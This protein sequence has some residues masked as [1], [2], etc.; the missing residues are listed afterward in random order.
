MRT[1]ILAAMLTA[2]TAV[3]GRAETIRLESVG[4]T[5]LDKADVPAQEAGPAAAVLVRE[6]QVVQ[7]GD[8]LVQLDD[9][10]RQ[11]ELQRARIERQ[12]AAE[13]AANDVKVRLGR[14]ALELAEVDM[15]RAEEANEQFPMSVTNSQLDR[16][17]LSIER[18]RLE[19]EQS[20]HEVAAARRALEAADHAVRIADA[21]IQRRKLVAPIAG[22][23]VEVKRRKGEWAQPGETIVRILRTDRLRAEGFVPAARVVKPWA[24]K[25]V[26]LH[27]AVAGGVGQFLGAVTFV[28]SEANPVNGQVRVLAE[29][30]NPLGTLRP[31]LVGSL[32]VDLDGGKSVVPAN[33][34]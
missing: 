17:R 19:I 7:A 14:K 8:L 32:T 31:G 1:F 9:V 6:G 15:R 22:V 34:E 26:V 5:L 18:A 12:N 10:D 13:I 23:V 16:L 11:L 2:Y 21:G 24:G 27:V 33:A 25:P 3:A 29:I 4:V 30:D 20:E 28:S